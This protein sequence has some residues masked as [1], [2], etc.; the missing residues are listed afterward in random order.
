[1]PILKSSK[2][3]V[4][5]TMGDPA[6][7]GPSIIAQAINKL[8]N[9]AEFVVIGDKWVFNQLSVVSCQLSVVNFIDLNNVPHKNFA[10]GRIKAEYGRASI[11]YLDKAQKLIRQRNID[12]LVTCPISKEAI[13]L[14]GFNYPGHTEYLAYRARTKNFAMLLLN[15]ALKI[16]L[17]TRHIPLSEVSAKLTKEK[18]YKTIILTYKSLKEWF[19]LKN[20]R[21]VVCGL[22]PHASDNG[23]IGDEESRVIKPVLRKLKKSIKY[24]DGPLPSDV[25]ISLA[26]EGQY[27][28]V[29]AMYHDQ[30][31]IP[32][33]LQ[34]KNTGVNMTLGLPFIRTSPLHGTAFDIAQKPNLANPGS[35]IEAIKLAVKCTLNL[36]KA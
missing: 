31:L 23:L 26:K 15:K 17:V 34:D 20:P 6:S 22:N 32:L 12:C 30:A 35:L 4:G 7:I 28:C 29:I 14:A 16:S 5:L 18:I 2:V 36:R 21:L 3:K 27:D 13:N 1:M 10:F 11:E 8:K 25:A 9:L 33:K 19:L 24:L